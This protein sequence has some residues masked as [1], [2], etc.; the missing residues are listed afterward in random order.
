MI[1]LMTVV[2]IATVSGAFITAFGGLIALLACGLMYQ[3][4]V[5]KRS[6]RSILWGVYTRE[7]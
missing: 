7:D 6:W 4:L 5:N 1:P 2:A 3:R